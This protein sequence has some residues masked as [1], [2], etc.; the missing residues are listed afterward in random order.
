MPSVIQITRPLAIQLLGLAQKSPNHEICGLV[1][2]QSGKPSRVYPIKN[3]AK[4]P[5][6]RFE[7]DP[8]SEIEA[9]RHIRESGEELFAI[10]H[11]HPNSPPVPS[12]QDL[13]DIG[14]PQAYYLIISLDIKGVLEM[15]AYR[16]NGEKATAVDL[17]V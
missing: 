12:S 6:R 16:L 9:F 17:T 2:M 8:Q 13:Q 7:M 3:I 14:Y 1:A 4:D 10:F 5:V 15:R 11:S